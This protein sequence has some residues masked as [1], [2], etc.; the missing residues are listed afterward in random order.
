MLLDRL[1]SYAVSSSGIIPWSS[2]IPFFGDASN[3]QVATV[4]INPSNREFVDKSGK[5]LEGLFRR[6]H[7]LSSLGLE[8]WSE[9]DS[10][11]LE[12]II[13]TCCSYFLGNPYNIWFKKLDTVIGGAKASYYD[14]LSNA[15]HFDLVPYATRCKWTELSGKQRNLLFELTGDVLGLTLRDSSVRILIL[16]GSSVVKIFQSISGICLQEEEIPAW[17]LQRKASPNVT[18]FAYTGVVDSLFGIPLGRE[19]AVLGFNHNL[20][21]SFGVSG[22]TI[23]AIRDWIAL[24]VEAMDAE[25][26]GSEAG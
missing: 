13:G 23:R 16:N 11:H 18:G 3:P 9:A 4:G 10:R 22:K 8:S 25:T 5:E 20:Q 19:V 26:Q 2:P 14:A 21:S 24:A 7:T 6:F 17:S 12:L 1:D 15:C